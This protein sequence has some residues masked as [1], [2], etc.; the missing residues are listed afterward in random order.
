M[1]EVG[2]A[3]TVF[4]VDDDEAVRDALRMLMQASRLKVE[5]FASASAFLTGY[6]PRTPGCL[7]LDVRM[8]GI[9]GLDLQDTLHKRRIDVPIIF[10][11]GHGDVPMAVRALKKGALDFIEKPLDEQRLVLAVLNALKVDALQRNRDLRSDDPAT[12]QRAALLSKR[13]RDVLNLVL[14]GMQT[15]DIAAE[16]NVSIKTV[17]FHRS[18][19]RKKLGISSLAELFRL[20]QPRIDSH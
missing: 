18:R 5:T 6:P 17:E 8:P 16:L 13:E 12:V 1:N 10:L 4:V 20:F 2:T 15:R 11:T 7:V 14:D 3:A 9:S 19:I